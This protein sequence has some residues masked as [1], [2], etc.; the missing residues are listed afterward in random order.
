MIACMKEIRGLFSELL[1]EVG[2]LRKNWGVLSCVDRLFFFFNSMNNS[3]L[4]SCFHEHN[5]CH[6]GLWLKNDWS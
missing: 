3:L 1:R 4:R 6:T 2:H 5:S